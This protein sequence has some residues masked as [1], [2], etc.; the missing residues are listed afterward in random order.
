[1]ELRQGGAKLREVAAAIGVSTRTL[2]RW[3]LRGNYPERAD[4]KRRSI[5]DPSLPY[6]ASRRGEGCHNALGV[7]RELRARGFRGSKETVRYHLSRWRALLP[8]H[9]R[10][11]SG[12]SQPE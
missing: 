11:S 9:L 2:R 4:Y 12:A 6:L 7:W 10:Y 5:L 3:A 8:A 1:M